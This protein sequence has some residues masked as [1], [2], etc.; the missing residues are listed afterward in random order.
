VRDARK[1]IENETL[2]L[3]WRLPADR[4]DAVGEE[5]LRKQVIGKRCGLR[6]KS[7]L[8]ECRDHVIEEHHAVVGFAG[9]HF[10]EQP[11][12]VM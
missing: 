6:A 10:L 1:L 7:A 8:Q 2:V 3:G 12:P 9:G 5:E 4:G 11:E